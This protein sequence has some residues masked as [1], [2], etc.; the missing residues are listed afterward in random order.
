M[1][2]VAV[3]V[4]H[5]RG[6]GVDELTGSSK[7]VKVLTTVSFK[8]QKLTEIGGRFSFQSEE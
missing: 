6:E 7:I 3:A 5:G 4:G 1:V 2:A 8:R